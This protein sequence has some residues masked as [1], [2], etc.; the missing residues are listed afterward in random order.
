MKITAAIAYNKA[1]D[2]LK[3]KFDKNFVQNFP[4]L[5]PKEYAAIYTD[6]KLP[7]SVIKYNK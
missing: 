4:N 1:V 6:I 2:E 7:D 3:K 5:G